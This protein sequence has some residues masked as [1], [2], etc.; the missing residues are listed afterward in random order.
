MVDPPTVIITLWVY[1]IHASHSPRTMSTCYSI[2]TIIPCHAVWWQRD[3]SYFKTDFSRSCVCVMPFFSTNIMLLLLQEHA[4][5]LSFDRCNC[6]LDIVSGKEISKGRSRSWLHN[7]LCEE[8]RCHSR[9]FP[10]HTGSPI[11][12]HHSFGSLVFFARHENTRIILFSFFM[13]IIY[14]WFD[15]VE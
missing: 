6:G 3:S 8:I 15:H 7:F 9:P 14:V 2:Y 13:W 10:L 5:C 12:I 4:R 11:F 1:H